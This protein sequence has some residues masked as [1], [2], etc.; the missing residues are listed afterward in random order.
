MRTKVVSV[1]NNIDNFSYEQYVKFLL[2]SLPRQVARLV[3]KI[4]DNFHC[5]C[6]LA[7]FQRAVFTVCWPK[8]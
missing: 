8:A 2:N 1:I 7:V 6:P 5:R 4:D 3:K